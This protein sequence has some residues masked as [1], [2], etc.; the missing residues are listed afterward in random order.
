MLPT[1][2]P[3]LADADPLAADEEPADAESDDAET[4]PPF[5]IPE[6][7]SHPASTGTPTPTKNDRATKDRRD[8][9]V[10]ETRNERKNA[11]AIGTPW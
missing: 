7:T 10:E 3:P 1:P 6:S 4:S 9:A 5:D 8:G 11:E 2:T